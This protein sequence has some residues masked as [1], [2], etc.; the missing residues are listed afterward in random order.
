MTAVQA[1][2]TVPTVPAAMVSNQ[3]FDE[4]TDRVRVKPIPWEGYSRAG[5]ISSDELQNLKAFQHRLADE[6]G[7]GGALAGYVPLLVKLAESLSS[8]DALQYLLVVL[9]DLVECDAAAVDAL[10]GAEMGE[11]V[12]RVMFRCMDKKDDYLGLK[13]CKI[14]IGIVAG[15]DAAV[16]KHVFVRMF[17]Y[18]ERCLKSELTSVVD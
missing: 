3:F 7:G 6:A 4:F 17:E 15:G 10:R 16:E 2:A 8:I 12:A 9:D 14:L 13:A 18:V 5:L 1:A 11:A